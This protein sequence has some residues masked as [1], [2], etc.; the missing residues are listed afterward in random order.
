MNGTS[1]KL[2]I[3]T[4]GDSWVFGCELVDPKITMAGGA[5]PGA[6]DYLEEN[7]KYR[8]PKIFPTHLEKLMNANVTNLSWPAD[9]NSTILRRTIVYITNNYIVKKKS[10]ENLF[11]IVG[12]SSPER[13]SFWYKDEKRSR[14]FRLWPQVAHFD[15]KPQEEFWKLYIQYLWNAEEYIPRYVLNVLQFQNFCDSNNIKWMCFNSFYQ[16][17]NKNVTEWHDLD[18]SKELENLSNGYFPYS[19][20]EYETIRQH[21]SLH[22]SGIWDIIDPIR[23]YKKNQSNNTFKSYIESNVDTPLTGWH[24]SPEGHEA[25]AKELQKY[26]TE[27]KLL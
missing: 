16:T 15:D 14:P 7:N 5:H 6:Y 19:K 8:I 26:I 13:N 2:E 12:W 24:P 3:I 27:N 9:D 23:F 10:V 18:I 1:D 4:D 20:T 11:V 25:W 21:E 22:Y 17:P